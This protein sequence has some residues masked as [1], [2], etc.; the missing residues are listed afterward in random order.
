MTAFWN[1]PPCS[2]A[3]A[4]KGRLCIFPKCYFQNSEKC[5]IKNCVIQLNQFFVLQMYRLI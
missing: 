1:V 2:L 5:M 4:K 3:F